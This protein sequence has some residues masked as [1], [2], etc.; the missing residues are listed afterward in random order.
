MRIIILALFILAACGEREKS[1]L[2]DWKKTSETARVN[3][4]RD[5][6]LRKCITRMS[7]LPN[8]ET[9]KLKDA[10]ELCKTGQLLKK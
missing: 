9:V 2:A 10:V 4:V 5:D 8:T 6:T 7:M 3:I 1:T